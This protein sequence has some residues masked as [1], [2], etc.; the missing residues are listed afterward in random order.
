MERQSLVRL[1]KVFEIE[2]FSCNTWI[3]LRWKFKAFFLNFLQQQNFSLLCPE[4]IWFWSH[5]EL[6]WLIYFSSSSCIC[7]LINFVF[8]IWKALHLSF[9]KLWLRM[10]GWFH[11]QMSIKFRFSLLSTVGVF[12]W[13]SN[14]SRF[15]KFNQVWSKL[16]KSWS[17]RYI[18]QKM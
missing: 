3:F 8:V 17:S 1:N 4:K 16:T 18:H 10:K 13:F 15:A 6:N 12:L 9:E 7:H 14:R 5:L 11:L 2:F